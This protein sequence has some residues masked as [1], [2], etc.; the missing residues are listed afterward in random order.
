MNTRIIKIFFIFF[1][2]FSLFSC[3]T[4]DTE[5]IFRQNLTGEVLIRYSVSQ[6]ALNIGKIDRFDDFLPLPI[7]EYRFRELAANVDGLRLISYRKEEKNNEVHITV[8]YE[9]RNIEALNAVVSNSNDTKIEVQRRGERT[10]YTQ[11]I[12][13]I[14]RTISQETIKLAQTIFS[15]RSINLKVT[16]PQNIRTV[17]SGTMTGR[18][19]QVSYNLPQLLSATDSVKWEV[20]W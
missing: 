3:I 16:A 11:Q 8:R 5:I 10:Y 15:D 4:I 6:A 9:F 13:A 2:S 7:E 20:S 1:L 17:N 18:S 12:G 14:N 19:A